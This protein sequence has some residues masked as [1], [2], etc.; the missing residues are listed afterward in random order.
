MINNNKNLNDNQNEKGKIISEHLASVN[1]D[2]WYYIYENYIN[3]KLKPNEK[4]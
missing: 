1:M 3:P 4:K 2:P